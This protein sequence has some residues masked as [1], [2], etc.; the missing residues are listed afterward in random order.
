MFVSM[1]LF[2]YRKHTG[3]SQSS[4]AAKLTAAGFPATQAL[5]SQWESGQVV[6]TAERCLQVEEVT[7]GEV[8]RSDLRPEL[9]GQ[10]GPEPDDRDRRPAAVEGNLAADPDANTATPPPCRRSPASA[11]SDKPAPDAIPTEPLSEAA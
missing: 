6:I 3:I 1:K 4:F 11:G 7:G 2:D 10:P 9:F 8:S 5:I